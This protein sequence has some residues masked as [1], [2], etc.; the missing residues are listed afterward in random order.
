[1]DMSSLMA[2]LI[3]IFLVVMVIMMFVKMAKSMMG[4]KKVKK[5]DVPRNPSER[6]IAH[7]KE[8]LQFNR[9]GHYRIK[10]SGDA[11]KKGYLL[12]WGLHGVIPDNTEYIFFVRRKRWFT[13]EKATMLIV[14]PHL[15]G[16]LNTRELLV[17]ARGTIKIGNVLY[18]I[19][20]ADTPK[21]QQDVL[22]KR[23]DEHFQTRLLQLMSSDLNT[24][25]VESP[26]ATI[27]NSIIQASREEYEI[28]E[29]EKMTEEERR[30]AS[31]EKD[32][33]LE[34]ERRRR[35]ASDSYRQGG[36]GYPGMYPMVGAQ[37]M[38]RGGGAG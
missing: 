17:K 22:W 15:V 37:N 8:S 31:K 12:G 30:A 11:Y 25:L 24:D 1:M 20:T 28:G 35:A 3:G 18:P 10:I 36:G 7:N 19:P 38:Y 34:E 27:R 13:K 14:E 6:L 21:A 29:M 2:P 4:S 5:V 32:R 9:S 16:D 23:R 26:K 33:E